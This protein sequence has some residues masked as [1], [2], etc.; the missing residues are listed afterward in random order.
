[1]YKLKLFEDFGDVKSFI[2]IDPDDISDELEL[3]DYSLGIE[4]V[5]N[6]LKKKLGDNFTVIKI[7]KNDINIFIC[8]KTKPYLWKISPLKDDYFLVKRSFLL[9]NISSNEMY[10]K[11]DDIKGI[12]KLIDPSY[13]FHT[14]YRQ[15]DIN[16]WYNNGASADNIK[17]SKWINMPDF[18]SSTQYSKLDIEKLNY[19]LNKES[20]P[21]NEVQNMLNTLTKVKLKVSKSTLYEIPEHVRE[22]GIVAS[23]YDIF[24]IKSNDNKE[25]EILYYYVED[26]NMFCVLLINLGGNVR[27][28]TC[29][30]IKGLK[31]LLNSI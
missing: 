30:D 26:F 20:Y 10:F 6:L 5:L 18:L 24:K 7:H 11:C 28:Y 19:Y 4:K 31:S 1:M 29:W 14:L 16:I 21:M 22:N 23:G 3:S 15:S 13:D 17:G 9:R 27:T 25:F 8:S 12:I 2:S